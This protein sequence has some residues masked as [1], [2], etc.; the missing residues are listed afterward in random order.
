MLESQ[1]AGLEPPGTLQHTLPWRQCLVA[2]TCSSSSCE[3]EAGV[4]S[5]CRDEPGPHLLLCPS[6]W[7]SCPA[8]LKTWSRGCCRW[9]LQTGSQLPM[10]CDTRTS[11]PYLHPSCTSKTV[12]P[13]GGT[14]PFR[15]TLSLLLSYPNFSFSSRVHF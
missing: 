14:S 15:S 12:S 6:G 1:G 11:A 4:G 8:G 3:P 2:L 7:T 9:F 5:A 13:G 10:L